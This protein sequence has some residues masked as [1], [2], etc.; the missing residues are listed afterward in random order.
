MK[1]DKHI[2]RKEITGQLFMNTGAKFLNKVLV[3]KIQHY[4]KSI[5]HC[6]HLRSFQEFKVGLT[7]GNQSL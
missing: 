6:N 5:I 4:I 2:V 3:N 1:S 7:S